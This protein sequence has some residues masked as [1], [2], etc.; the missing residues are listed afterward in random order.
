MLGPT[1]RALV[2]HIAASAVA[3]G[4]VSLFPAP[5]GASLATA[6]RRQMG[7]TTEYDRGY[8]VI[9]YPWGDVPRRTGV[10]CDVVIRAA[11]DAWGVDLQQLVHEDMAVDFAAYPHRWNLPAP[12]PNIDHR[13]VPNLETY[14]AR[15]GALLWRATTRKVGFDFGGG[16]LQAGDLLTWRT[17]LHSGGTHIAM[18]SAGGLVPRIVQNF[19]WGVQEDWLAVAILDGAAAHI[20]WLPRQA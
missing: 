6:A 17:F 2:R 7:V 5:S 15:A 14:F 8:H 10:C 19:G 11:R 1:R 4:K 9:G 13:R 20:R 18:V 12:D 16:Q 3:G